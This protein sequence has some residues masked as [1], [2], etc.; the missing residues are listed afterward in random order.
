MTSVIAAL[1]SASEKKVCAR[2]RPRMYVCANLTPAST[3]ALP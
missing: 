1:H 3:F 2:N